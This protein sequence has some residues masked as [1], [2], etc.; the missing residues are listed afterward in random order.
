M[1][2]W[3]PFMRGVCMQ[4]YNDVQLHANIARLELIVDTGPMLRHYY[5]LRCWL[6]VSRHKVAPLQKLK[7][8]KR[9]RAKIK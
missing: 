3:L 7:Q 6:N 1:A 8:Y 2:H 9:E 4:K 5:Q